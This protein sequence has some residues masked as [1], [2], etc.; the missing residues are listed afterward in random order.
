MV[1]ASA[2]SKLTKSNYQSCNKQYLLPLLCKG[3]GDDQK[4]M[5]KE[6]LNWTEKEKTNDRMCDDTQWPFQT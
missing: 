3:V 2:T 4:R 6:E 1:S 5:K